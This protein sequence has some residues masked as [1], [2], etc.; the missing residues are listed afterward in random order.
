VSGLGNQILESIEHYRKALE[1]P[2]FIGPTQ[3]AYE[4]FADH[5]DEVSTLS[6]KIQ[7]ISAGSR[8]QYSLKFGPNTADEDW[9]EARNMLREELE[10]ETRVT[11][12]YS[13]FESPMT[14]EDVIAEIEN[15]NWGGS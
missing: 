8:V 9:L 2:V 1:I 11:Q 13:H 14:D 4:N 7:K 12:L 5:K 6:E 10:K 3:Y 15:F